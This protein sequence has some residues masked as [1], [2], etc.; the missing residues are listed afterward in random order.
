M[1]LRQHE[2]HEIYKTNSYSV[3]N[4]RFEARPTSERCDTTNV[5][6]NSITVSL[7][8][9]CHGVLDILM[10]EEGFGIV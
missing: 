7:L 2:E 1:R 8:P 3:T 4:V 9:L 10:T 6:C 5:R